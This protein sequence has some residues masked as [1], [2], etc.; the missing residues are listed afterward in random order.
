MYEALAGV[1][2]TY[3]VSLEAGDGDELIEDV[4][5]T[6]DKAVLKQLGGRVRQALAT[7][8]DKERHFIEKHY[9]EDK[10]L[11]D[12]GAELGLSK[13]WASRLHARAIELLRKALED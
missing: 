9:F 11:T 10:T 2:T 4:P 1:A 3:V 13:S 6:E 7:L 5:S 8:P 12:A